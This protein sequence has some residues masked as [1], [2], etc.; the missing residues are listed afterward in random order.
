MRS[1]PAKELFE[2]QMWAS[3][4]EKLVITKSTPTPYGFTHR[5]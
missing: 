3:L 2:P 1:A 5:P 4:T